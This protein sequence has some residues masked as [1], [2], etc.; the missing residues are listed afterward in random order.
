MDFTN[1]S[2]RSDFLNVIIN[3]YGYK[4][5]LE[6]GFVGYHTTFNFAKV[7]CH[8]KTGVDPGAAIYKRPDGFEGDT[9]TIESDVFFKNIELPGGNKFD[10]IFIDGLHEEGQTDR[11]IKNSLNYLTDD[12]IIVCH[13]TLP[14][15]YQQVFHADGRLGGLGT[16]YWSFAKLRTE[17]KNLSM[18]SLDFANEPSTIEGV[19]VGIIKKGGQTLFPIPIVDKTTEEEKYKF[20]VDNKQNLM[21]VVKLNRFKEW[22][23]EN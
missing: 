14:E 21:N 11:D 4:N 15:Y 6:I 13:D 19:G 8:H 3:L 5:Y 23:D 9:H 7:I 17:N 20:Y 1:F 10:I 22:L 16:S 2:D 12:G 18:C